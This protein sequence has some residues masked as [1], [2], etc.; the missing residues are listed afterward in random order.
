MQVTGAGMCLLS[1]AWVDW[2]GRIVT[3]LKCSQL[4]PFSQETLS[5]TELCL[6]VPSPKTPIHRHC[7]TLTPPL[8]RCR[9]LLQLLHCGRELVH[10]RLLPQWCG[11]PRAQP[12]PHPEVAL[13]CSCLSL[14]LQSPAPNQHTCVRHVS[15]HNHSPAP[16]LPH[17]TPHLHLLQCGHQLVH[18]ALLLQ[19]CPTPATTPPG[20]TCSCHLP[21]LWAPSSYM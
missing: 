11:H 17:C 12:L 14:P 13:T 19:W 7:H 4:V 20:P 16:P 2:E 3:G 10:S 15:T 21:L 8:H 9:P 1:T 6:T 18:S 5:T